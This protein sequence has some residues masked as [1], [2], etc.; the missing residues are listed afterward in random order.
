MSGS[1]WRWADEVE[2]GAR[3]GRVRLWL[4]RPLG[5][6]EALMVATALQ[7]PEKSLPTLP[8]P[9]NGPQ[10]GLTPTLPLLHEY[11]GY[12]VSDWRNHVGFFWFPCTFLERKNSGPAVMRGSFLGFKF[13]TSP[14]A[15]SRA[16]LSVQ[17]QLSHKR[18]KQTG[19][20]TVSAAACYRHYSSDKPGRLSELPE[21]ME[22]YYTARRPVSRH[23]P[24][25]WPQKITDGL[26]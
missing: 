19:Q 20:N 13:S 9:T 3:T 7:R 18:R 5:R 14:G 1:S 26:L 12:P 21:V 11:L 6:E 15:G 10:A 16:Q 25:L 8:S 24:K 17:G 22:L 23:G 4:R 2:I